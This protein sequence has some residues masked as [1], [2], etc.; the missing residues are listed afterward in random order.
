MTFWRPVE[1]LG[2]TGGGK[3]EGGE[4]FRQSSLG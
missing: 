2:K 1:E 4:K 3:M